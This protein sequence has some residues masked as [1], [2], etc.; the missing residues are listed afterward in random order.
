MA[1]G[2]P[3]PDS[4]VAN[5]IRLH[6]HTKPSDANPGDKDSVWN[7]QHAFVSDNNLVNGFYLGAD[8]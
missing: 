2:S 4:V 8:K 6:G 3:A 1:H 7:E 5:Q